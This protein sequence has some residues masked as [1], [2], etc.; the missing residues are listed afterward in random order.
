[1]YKIQFKYLFGLNFIKFKGKNNKIESFG[2]IKLT[3]IKL[4]GINNVIY[5]GKNTLIKNCNFYIKGTG[6]TVYIGD[7][8][9]INNT[10]IIMEGKNGKIKIGN[11]TTVAKLLISSLEDEIIDIGEDCMISYDVEIR[12]TDSHMI[13][14]KKT[15]QRINKGKPVKIGN[16]VWLGMRALILKGTT[17]GDNSIVAAGSIVTSDVEENTIVSGIP[18]KKIKEDIYWT[19]EEVFTH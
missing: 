15:N 11:K 8:C 3:K 6:N 4:S 13:F 19:R 12:N 18:A 5:V 14:D 17:I 1:M 2:K 7:N 9:D 16:N 10:Q